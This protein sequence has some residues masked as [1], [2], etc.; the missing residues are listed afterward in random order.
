MRPETR[1]G[2]NNARLTDQRMALVAGKRNQRAHSVFTMVGQLAG[3]LNAT[4]DRYQWLSTLNGCNWI[5]R[6]ARSVFTGLVVVSLISENL[7][8]PHS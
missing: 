2:A 8:V 7:H 3:A 1:F 4:V 5:K 6:P